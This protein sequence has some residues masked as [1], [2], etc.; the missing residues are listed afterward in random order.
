[1]EKKFAGMYTTRRFRFCALVLLSACLCC[2]GGSAFGQTAN[3]I[4]STTRHN[5]K[6]SKTTTNVNPQ[7]R[8]EARSQMAEAIAARAQD[9]PQF[10]A[11]VDAMNKHK[12]RVAAYVRARRGGK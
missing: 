8:Q 5:H 6:A 7:R 9:D 2:F 10:R 4:P 1:M 12:Q 3:T 11:Y